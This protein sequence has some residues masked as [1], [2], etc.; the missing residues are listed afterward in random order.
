MRVMDFDHGHQ[1]PVHNSS[2]Y[3]GVPVGAR[4]LMH[5]SV[6]GKT[7]T[8]KRGVRQRNLALTASRH[9][10]REPPNK[11]ASDG[12]TRCKKGK[13]ANEINLFSY[14]LLFLN[15][16]YSV[17]HYDAFSKYYNPQRS[18]SS[19]SETNMVYFIIVLITLF[20]T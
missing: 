11:T 7:S 14:L 10:D 9:P 4:R 1:R 18:Y 6:H 17:M 3:S 13:I 12:N 2:I 20:I 19:S 16:S 8:E 15:I 5:S